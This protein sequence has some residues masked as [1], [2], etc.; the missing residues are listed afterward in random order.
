MLKLMC[1]LLTNFMLWHCGCQ[2]IE[3]SYK[4]M[5]KQ[6][7]ELQL[8]AK[9]KEHTYEMLVTDKAYLSKQVELHAFPP[10]HCNILLSSPNLGRW[11]PSHDPPLVG[12]H[13]FQPPSI[14]RSHVHSSQQSTLDPQRAHGLGQ[15]TLNLLLTH[16]RLTF[17]QT[18]SQGWRASFR[19]GTPRLQSCRSRSRTC[20]TG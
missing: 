19:S 16:H 12:R 5:E 15:L 3:A 17:C 1:H 6:F 2:V 11:P 4:R 9:E 14:W 20:S 8:F 18:R 10:F 13:M 7:H